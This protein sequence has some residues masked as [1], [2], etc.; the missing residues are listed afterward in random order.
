[1][2]YTPIEYI[3][4]EQN[5]FNKII[6]EEVIKQ[7]LIASLKSTI[8]LLTSDEVLNREINKLNNDKE[9]A[10]EIKEEVN[11]NRF[12]YNLV[13]YKFVKKYWGDSVAEKLIHKLSF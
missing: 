13:I 10:K 5:I 12:A 11:N 7:L 2:S 8:S 6:N 9:L 4:I 3:E 1:M